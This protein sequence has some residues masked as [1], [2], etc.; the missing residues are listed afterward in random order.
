MYKF[1][2]HLFRWVGT[3]AVVL[4]MAAPLW[5]ADYSNYS[6]EELANMRGTLSTATEQERNAFRAEWQKRMKSMTAE[7]RL[8]YV[9]P[10][11]TKAKRRSVTRRYGRRPGRGPGAGMGT[12]HPGYGKNR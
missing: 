3:T 9:G 7:E 10:P 4:M 8:K 6:T 5:A 12:G 1:N 2:K 11:K